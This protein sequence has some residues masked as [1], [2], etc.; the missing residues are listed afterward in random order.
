[1]DYLLDLSAELVDTVF[2]RELATKLFASKRLTTVQV[3]DG[4]YVEYCDGTTVRSCQLWAV[5]GMVGLTVD[6]SLKIAPAAE[7][8]R[9]LASL[10][11]PSITKERWAC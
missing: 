2:G 9:W 11:R 7:A 4:L 10:W 8:Y 6:S 1:M 5:D 3:C